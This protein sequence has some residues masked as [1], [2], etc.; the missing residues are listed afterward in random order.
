M[1]S[2]KS[3]PSIKPNGRDNGVIRLDH[4][5]DYIQ[6]RQGSGNTVEITDISVVS[7]RR[8]GK[9]RY[10]VNELISNFVSPSIVLVWA[11]TRADNLIAQQF[12]EE[13]RFRVVG[14]LR[15][16]YQDEPQGK[17]M[18]DAIMYGRDLRSQA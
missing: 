13:L 1:S 9:G 5:E 4:P 8:K 10:L 3:F 7:E 18:V 14:V 15:H 11:I 6:Y 16:F 2:F 12:Y 17:G